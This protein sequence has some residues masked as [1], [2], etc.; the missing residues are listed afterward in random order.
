MLTINDTEI[1]NIVAYGCS[2]T[3]GE[4][5]F[6]H[7]IHKRADYI[8]RKYGFMH[9]CKNHWD[10]ASPTLQ[11]SV[12]KEQ[13]KAVWAG[14][15]A[16]H[17][18]IPYKNRAL[19]GSSLGHAVL[20]FEKDLMANPNVGGNTLFLFGITGPDRALL[21]E[22]KHPRNFL[23]G[24]Y[25]FWPKNNWDPKTV[26]DL[27]SDSYL[28]WH[29]LLLIERLVA[30]SKERHIN[31]AIYD[32]WNNAKLIDSTLFDITAYARPLFEAKYKQLVETPCVFFD[33]SL[34][35]L[36]GGPEEMHGGGHPIAVVHQ[37]FADYVI[38]TLNS[39]I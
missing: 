28:I 25:E 8:K 18:G 21:F 9:W 27:F 3:A 23:I 1:T 37:R 4:E 35:G 29:H 39:V 19:G 13:Y 2:W 31:V 14:R 30:I 17:F 11:K 22:E 5:L 20:E 36:V 26:T 15:V 10:L 6:D 34:N 7:L 16:E 38:E 12:K 32:M 24:N 33:Q